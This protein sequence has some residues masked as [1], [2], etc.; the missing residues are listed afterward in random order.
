M[1]SDSLFQVTGVSSGIAWDEIISKIVENAQKPATQ[2]QNRIDTLEVKKT[3]YQDLQSQFNTLRNTLTKLR[4]SSAYNTK[5]A[6]YTSYSSNNVDPEKIVSAKINNAAE[7]SWWD[8]EVKNLARAQRH[9]SSR[10]G[11]VSEALGLEGDFMIRVG[12]QYT[13]ISVSSD[14]TLR[15]IN[16]NISKAVDQNG[17]TMAVT[18]KILD[19]RIVIESAVAGLGNSGDTRGVDFTM[20]SATEYYLPHASTRDDNNGTYVYPPQILNLY[21]EDTNV[22]GST[23][24]YYYKEGTDFKYDSSTGKITWL[25]NGKE[26]EKGVDYKY[27]SSGKI[28]WLKNKGNN[29]P[30]GTTFNAIYSDW[31]TLTRDESALLL[32]GTNYDFLPELRTGQLYPNTDDTTDGAT[33]GYFTIISD[34]VEYREGFDFKIVTRNLAGKDYQLIEWN[35]IDTQLPDPTPSDP[36]N[37]YTI[38]TPI[39]PANNKTLSVRVGANTGYTYDENVFYLE[40]ATKYSA[41]IGVKRTGTSLSPSPSWFDSDYM[42]LLPSALSTEEYKN[43]KFEITGSDGTTKYTQGTDF[44]INTYTESGKTY[45]V[46]EWISTGNAP[47]DNTTFKIRAVVDNDY[48]A[49]SVLAGLGFITAADDGLSVDQ[50][51]FTEGTYTNASSAE[52]EIDGV[53]ITRDT[54]TIDDVI[55]NVTLELTGLGQVRLNIVRDM[56]ETV[57]NIQ[58]FVDAY[59]KVLEWINF[60][61]AEKADGANSVDET[62]YLSSLLEQSKGSTVYGVLHGDQLLWNIK[63]QLR[64]RLSNPLTTLTSSLATKGVVNTTDS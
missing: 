8:I 47:S 28:T 23:Y 16:Y 2:W 22:D 40:P 15:D 10:V 31:T 51:T 32:P 24:T 43:A 59:N 36:S 20:T 34:G 25:N 44:K 3:L 7:L 19:N 54:N 4:L 58:A 46:I 61:V 42:D 26:Y 53:P 29:P 35:I 38:K 11:S 33:A 64:T 41:D 37:M 27:D 12:K 63:N 49:N 50:W 39:P 52:F 57:E 9:M 55:A 17:Q 13:T 48:G 30:E 56:E 14:D 62:D 18:A 5:K 6:E 45:K 60:Y 21:R 1:A